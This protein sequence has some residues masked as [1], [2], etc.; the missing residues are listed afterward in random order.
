MKTEAF[1]AKDLAVIS[2]LSLIISQG[3]IVDGVAKPFIL[4]KPD[5]EF[6]AYAVKQGVKILWIGP[7]G[8]DLNG[9]ILTNICSRDSVACR[10]VEKTGAHTSTT[11]M[12]R[13]SN[14][15]SVV[16]YYPG[17]NSVFLPSDIDEDYLCSAGVKMV[18]IASMLQL[19]LFCE[20]HAK[21]TVAKI[22]KLRSKDVN[23]TIGGLGRVSWAEDLSD[24]DEA[25]IVCNLQEYASYMMTYEHIIECIRR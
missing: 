13:P 7:V 11:H 14:L 18:Y 20:N 23:V 25:M 10:F 24:M 22:Q 15:G 12:M 16:E 2:P 17:A 21:R 1:E 5:I 3:E 6:G 8:R 9:E 4:S 19:P